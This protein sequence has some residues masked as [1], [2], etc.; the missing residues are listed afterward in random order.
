MLS[1]QVMLGGK[2]FFENN[3]QIWDIMVIPNP[4]INGGRSLEQNGDP[5]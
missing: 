1:N 5:C 4:G 2:N 3:N